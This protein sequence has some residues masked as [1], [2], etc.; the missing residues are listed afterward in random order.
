MNEKNSNLT[1]SFYDFKICQ[2][3]ASVCFCDGYEME[4]FVV[5]AVGHRTD[6]YKLNKY[7][8]EWPRKDVSWAEIRG[9][10]LAEFSRQIGSFRQPLITLYSYKDNGDC[11]ADFEYELLGISIKECVVRFKN[12][13]PYVYMPESYKKQWPYENIEWIDIRDFIAKQCKQSTML[14]QK[15]ERLKHKYQEYIPIVSVYDVT[16]E[17][18]AL[19]DIEIPELE[20]TVKAGTIY[21]MSD[22]NI[23]IYLPHDYPVIVKHGLTRKSV[24]KRIR[25]EYIKQISGL[26]ITP[27]S[28]CEDDPLNPIRNK[29]GR[30]MNAEGAPFAFIP[31]T[32]LRP[33]GAM[34]DNKKTLRPLLEALRN[35]NIG[36]FEIDTLSLIEKFRYLTKSMIIDLFAGGY[37]SH[38]WRN[39]ITLNKLS[40]IFNR[41]AKYKLVNVSKFMCVD[42]SD[43]NNITSEAMYQIYTL[44]ENGN[45]LLDELSRAHHYN[46]FDVYQNGNFVKSILASNQLLTYWLS[47]YPNEINNNYETARKVNVLGAEKNGARIYSLV[48][49]GN[50]SM[51]GEPV[52]RT[53][54]FEVSVHRAEIQDKLLRLINIANFE[55]DLYAVVGFKLEEFKFPYKPIICYICEDDEHMQEVWNTVKSISMQHPYQELWFTTDSRLFNYSNEN[56]RFIKFSSDDTFEIINLH[57]QLG[58]GKEREYESLD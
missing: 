20:Y 44:G 4:N 21:Y 48:T 13:K 38:G 36:A 14:P 10:I 39:N 45:K 28:K 5:K 46:P 55:G 47:A 57:E 23:N 18:T 2:C 3:K 1:V 12:N 37:I 25:E 42:D 29:Y 43:K 26:E 35:N 52:R 41:L 6:V 19:F 54:D 58:V 50:K 24:L 27:Y 56:N 7:D 33:I 49:I 40:L 53:Y 51:I 30:I 32:E 17:G 8:I 34:T 15:E 9:L 16:S 31:H 22:D 11:F